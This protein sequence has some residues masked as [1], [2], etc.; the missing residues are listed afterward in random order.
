MPSTS[1]IDSMVRFSQ[2]GSQKVRLA[3]IGKLVFG[4]AVYVAERPDGLLALF[5]AFAKIPLRP[6][7]L[8]FEG[9]L[10]EAVGDIVDDGVDELVEVG[11]LVAV[12]FDDETDIG[13][14]GEVGE[15]LLHGPSL[16]VD[17]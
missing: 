15:N 4:Y 12:G 8:F 7:R 14:E 16:L 9:V 2:R 1:A 17:R 13:A 11:G 6:R 3:V 10:V 5:Q